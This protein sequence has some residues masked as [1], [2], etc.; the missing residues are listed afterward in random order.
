MSCTI[1]LLHIFVFMI[2]GIACSSEVLHQSLVP[3]IWSCGSV[4]SLCTSAGE[5]LLR[6]DAAQPPVSESTQ[7]KDPRETEVVTLALL[8]P[9]D[10]WHEVHSNPRTHEIPSVWI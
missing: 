10:A 5:P 7:V 4:T 2:P 1:S 6:E 3:M 9:K 8:D